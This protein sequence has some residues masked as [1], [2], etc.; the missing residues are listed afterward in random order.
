MISV[1]NFKNLLKGKY[2]LEKWYFSHLIYCK[3][4]E[5]QDG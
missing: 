4:S 2:K 5:M 3:I 1:A